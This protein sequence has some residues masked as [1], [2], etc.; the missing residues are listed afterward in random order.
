[1]ESC[2]KNIF[3]EFVATLYDMKLKSEKGSPQYVIAKLLLN[4]LYGRFAIDPNLYKHKL[5]TEDQLDKYA[6][7]YRIEDVDSLGN[8]KL[9]IRYYDEKVVDY[10]PEYQVMNSSIAISAAVTAGARTYMNYFLS[11]YDVYYTD[12]DSAYIKGKLDPKFVDDIIG[13]F[14]LEGVFDEVI[15][16]ASKVRGSTNSSG[17][18]TRVKG[19]KSPISFS[20]LKSLL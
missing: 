13:Q 20:Q 17:E 19:L 10:K 1:M 14:K 18:E 3:K 15:F 7:E 11:N 9:L 2:S 12:T 6:L 5:I 4:S 16:L 8:G